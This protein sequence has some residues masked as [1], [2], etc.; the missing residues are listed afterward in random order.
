VEFAIAALDCGVL[1]Q[2]GEF[3]GLPAG[4]AVLSLLTQPDIWAR[5]LALL[6]LD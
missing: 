3:Y 1:V 5:G 2:P 4:R 6:P